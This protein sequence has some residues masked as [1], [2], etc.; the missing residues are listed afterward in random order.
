ML[1]LS[2]SMLHLFFKQI[3]NATI[4]TKVINKLVIGLL[5]VK[6]LNNITYRHS[7]QR[8]HFLQT[9][10]NLNTFSIKKSEKIDALEF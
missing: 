7:M 3:K 4:V 1:T 8:W 5:C 9:W 10:L 6:W 2:I